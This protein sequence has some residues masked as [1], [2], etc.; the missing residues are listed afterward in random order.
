MHDDLRDH[1]LGVPMEIAAGGGEPYEEGDEA[2]FT[3]R[4]WLSRGL[5]VP[6]G[7]SM[8]VVHFSAGART[9]WHA[10]PGGQLLYGVSGRG[11]VRSRG[12]VGHVL[13]AGQMVAIP[14]G[15]WHYHG[16]APG[17]PMA[18]ISVTT[19]GALEWGAPVTDQEYT[20]G[21]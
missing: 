14:A 9:R 11:W 12:G 2:R 18:H 4:V 19:G 7:A 10:H 5:T 21:F 16:G 8:A 20:E 17:S 6:G 15:E 1:G 3:G 13:T